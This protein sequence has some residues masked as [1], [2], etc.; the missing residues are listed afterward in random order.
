MLKHS[1]QL[2]LQRE[3]RHG[4]RRIYAPRISWVTWL[5]SGGG[6]DEALPAS[7][8]KANRQGASN[9]DADDEGDADA[10]NSKENLLATQKNGDLE[11][12]AGLDDGTTS[13]EKKATASPGNEPAKKHYIR[14]EPTSRWLRFRGQLADSL[15]WLQDSD[16][17]LYAVKITIAVFLV[18]WPALISSWNTWYSLNRGCKY[19]TSDANCCCLAHG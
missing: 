17:V 6:E 10:A 18:V 4:R 2:V 16:D 14:Q 9:E 13:L 12:T 1:R 5:Y 3:Q 15:E 8:S 7:G 11:K 19:R